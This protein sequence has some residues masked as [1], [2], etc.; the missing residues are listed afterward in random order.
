MPL[1]QL[2]TWAHDTQRAWVMPEVGDYTPLPQA[3]LG[4][5]VEGAVDPLSVNEVGALPIFSRPAN[6]KFFIDIFNQGAGDLK[7]T[8]K[9]S[10]PW[11]VLSQTSAN[12]DVRITVNI[13]WQQAPYGNNVSGFITLSGAGAE[14]RIDLGVFNPEGL[15]VA[16]LPNAVENNSEVKIAAVDYIENHDLKNG[17][18]WRRVNQATATGDGM[19]IQPVT[20]ASIDLARLTEDSPSLTYN[21]Y[22]F[23]IGRVKIHTQCL[24]THKITSEH[25]GLRYAISLNGDKPRIVDIHANEYSEAWNVNTLRAA[26]IGIS[27]HEIASP[28]IQNIKIWMVDAGVVLDSLTVNI[29]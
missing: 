12:G 13:D 27:G 11:I 29:D 15:D 26:A 14:R 21:F 2:P 1:S 19:T 20:A 16:A 3:R 8:A 23:S 18:G 25:A 24:P 9:P 17:T 28:G 10:A 22:S 7:W 6:S 4:V 5:V